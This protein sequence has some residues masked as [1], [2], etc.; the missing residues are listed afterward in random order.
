MEF[1]EWYEKLNKDV[2]M[3]S[4]T[5]DTLHLYCMRAWNA[6]MKEY[7]SLLDEEEV[8]RKNKW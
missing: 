6:G 3:D 2:F 7:K 5:L 4:P 1:K 8:I